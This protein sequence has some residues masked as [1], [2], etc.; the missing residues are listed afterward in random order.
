M[1]I[2]DLMEQR[3]RHLAAGLFYVERMG[4]FTI[5]ITMG[6]HDFPAIVV[7]VL[8]DEIVLSLR[9]IRSMD[10]T[11]LLSWHSPEYIW[12]VFCELAIEAAKEYLKP[13]EED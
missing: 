12:K 13:L 1:S 11:K 10:V 2:C 8:K 3:L 4:P 7:I 5:W 6:L 9:N